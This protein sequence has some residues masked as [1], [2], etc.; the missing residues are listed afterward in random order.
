MTTTN[1]IQKYEESKAKLEK[2]LTH[3]H[4]AVAMAEAMVVDS[5]DS[6]KLAGERLAS[7]KSRRSF[8]EGMKEEVCV[9]LYEIHKMAVS[10]F[11]P[12]IDGWGKCEKALNWKMSAYDTEQELAARKRQDQLRLAAE[13]EAAKERAEAEVL[14]REAEVKGDDE[15]AQEIR[16]DADQPILPVPMIPRGVPKIEG[17][18][19]PTVVWHYE[20]LDIDKV[21]EEY[22][23]PKIEDSTKIRHE[24][25]RTN[26]K[27]SIPGIKVWKE[28]SRSKK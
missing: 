16:D 26:G 17:L 11:R 21:P 15:R 25:K 18:K 24:A 22:L 5:T 10:A 9:P 7:S 23:K 8:I 1:A 27:C 6:Y 14:A 13:A 4:K 20:L 12:L 2:H 28:T 3:V 19:A